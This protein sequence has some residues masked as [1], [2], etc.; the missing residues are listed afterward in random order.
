MMG[1]WV[2]V[3]DTCCGAVLSVRIGVPSLGCG[4]PNSINVDLSGTD[5]CALRYRPAHSASAALMP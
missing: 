4:W 1:G 2:F 5:S 3:H